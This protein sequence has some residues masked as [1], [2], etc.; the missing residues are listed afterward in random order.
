MK[1]R[2]DFN[3]PEFLC[4]EMLMDHLFFVDEMCCVIDEPH[5][6]VQAIRPIVEYITWI[7][8]LTETYYAGWPVYLGFHGLTHH[9]IA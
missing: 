2:Q 5:E 8:L 6:R 3:F 9:H 1:K 4:D 7:F